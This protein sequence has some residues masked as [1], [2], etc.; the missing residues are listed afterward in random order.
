[1]RIKIMQFIRFLYRFLNFIDFKKR[2]KE[3]F[4]LFFHL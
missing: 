4:I 3:G 1:M 2:I